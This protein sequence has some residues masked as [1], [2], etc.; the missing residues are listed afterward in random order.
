MCLITSNTELLA[1]TYLDQTGK[2]PTVS[3]RGKQYIFILY[4]YNTNSI[5]VTLL[6]NRQAATITHAW[7][8]TFTMLKQHGVASQLHILDNEC[9]DD[10]VKAFNKI[11][12]DFKKCLPAFIVLMQLNV[13]SGRSK[14]I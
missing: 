12:V 13:P 11:N 1:K 8:D 14:T 2:F 7:K 5:H 4:H 6:K 9:S 10:L 3:S